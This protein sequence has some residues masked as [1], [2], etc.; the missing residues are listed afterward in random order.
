M[1]TH[2]KVPDY[3]KAS[4]I[5]N[6]GGNSGAK[7]TITVSALAADAA[8]GAAVTQGGV[9]TGKMKSAASAGATEIVVSYTS[10]CKDGGLATK[11]LSGCFTTTGSISVG[12]AD[13]GA[14]TAVANSYRTLA[15][16]S[17]A[18]EKKMTGQVFYD[19]YKAYYTV[20]DYA[21]VR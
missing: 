12:G 9:A 2:L 7:A 17:T 16:F 15:G 11:D 4:A 18:A 10:V 5:Y 21:H 6:K 3:T 19:Q 14:A 8:K 13:V 1:E 20:G